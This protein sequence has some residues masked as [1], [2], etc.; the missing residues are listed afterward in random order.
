[1]TLDMRPEQKAAAL[2]VAVGAEAAAE[3]L[4]YLTEEEVEAIAVEV[5]KIGRLHPEVVEALMEEVAQQLAAERLLATGGI[6]Y[7]KELLTAWESHRGQEIIER[8]LADL[9]VSPFSFVR[10]IEP[11]ALIHILKDEHPQTVALIL[12]YQTPGYAA[13]VIRGFTPSMQAEVAFRM[14]TMGKTS[15]EVIRRVEEALQERLGSVSSAE[16]TVRGGVEDL[17]AVLNNTDRTTERAIL[18]RLAAVDPELAER[19]RALMF[20]FED[21][22]SLDDRSI[23]QVLKHV[24]TK[25]LAY[26]MKGVSNE[27]REAVL[28]NMSQRA[29]ESLLEEIELLGAVR[30]SDVEAA[31]SRIVAVVRRLEEEGEIIIARGGET[32]LVE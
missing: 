14:A 9:S 32:E 12:A 2:V 15:P 24:D 17:A 3:I 11:D 8:L 21:I 6:D 31:Q 18:E 28:R 5:A 26:A 23:Q 1:M 30:R 19:V 7:A 13:E 10:S 20:V 27:V 29:S 4:Q 16:V 25:D 22:A